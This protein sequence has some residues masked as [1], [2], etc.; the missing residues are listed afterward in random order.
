VS[1]DSNSTKKPL[2]H[3][4]KGNG[5][6]VSDLLKKRRIELS[7][8]LKEVE[9]ATKI[10]KK[11]LQWIESGDYEHLT[12]DV[13]ALG[14]IKSYADYLGF[15]TTPIVNMY[16]KERL[17]YKQNKETGGYIKSDNNMSLKPLGGQNFVLS[18][19]TLVLMFSI[20]LFVMISGY[21][22]WQVIIIAA[23]PN[24]T[25]NS[26]QE[27]VTTDF[28]IISG[29]TDGDSDVYIDNSPISTNTDGSFSERV[30]LVSGSNVITVSAKNQLGKTTTVTRTVIAELPQSSIE[31]AK[32][33]TTTIDGVE[34][35]VSIVNQATYVVVVADGQDVF[36]GTMLP[37]AN[38]VFRA[39][40]TI[41][42]TTGN[43]GNTQVGITNSVVAGKDL[44]IIGKS[45]EAK[46]DLEFSKDTQFE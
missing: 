40:N 31:Q 5:L 10:R 32:L 46:N 15:D 1:P 3:S 4:S 18:S 37:G 19:K 38:Q 22:A 20:M 21:L 7:K 28:V 11:Y 30:S 43:A 12:D 29:Q 9:S 34:L 44:G 27:R 33:S 23:P 6:T 8:S 24:I 2:D 17:I 16:K 39:K 13:Y 42:L 25:L 14:Y 41:K 35:Q 36:R 45:G 26:N